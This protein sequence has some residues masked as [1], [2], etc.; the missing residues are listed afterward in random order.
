MKEISFIGN[1]RIQ[2]KLARE[3]Q[4]KTAIQFMRI[5]KAL[6]HLPWDATFAEK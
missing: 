3:L 2:T 5:S 4:I 1:E 6:V